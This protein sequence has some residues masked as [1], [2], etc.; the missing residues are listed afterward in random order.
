MPSGANASTTALMIAAGTLEITV[1]EGINPRDSLFVCGGGGTSCHIAEMADILGLKR[2]L[3]PRFV[4]GLSAFG[5]LIS[6]LRWEEN[7]TLHTSS[8]QFDAKRVTELLR[9]L[10]ANA[11]VRVRVLRPL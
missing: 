1:R 8:R 2:Y 11:A 5:G 4:A 7:G 6:D 9:R 10:R 3:I